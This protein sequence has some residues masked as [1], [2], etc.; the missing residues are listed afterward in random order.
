[1]A[2]PPQTDGNIVWIDHRV[3]SQALGFISLYAHLSAFSV[4]DGQGFSQGDQI[5]VSG[6]SD[7]ANVG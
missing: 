4:A 2:N 1:L 7:P 6:N 5:G 3:N